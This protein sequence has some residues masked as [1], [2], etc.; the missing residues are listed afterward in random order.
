MSD[1]FH[2]DIETSFDSL[3]KWQQPMRN[4][5][6]SAFPGS[7]VSYLALPNGVVGLLVISPSFAGQTQAER[8]RR[9]RGILDTIGLGVE[10]LISVFHL[11]T[12]DENLN[13]DRQAAFQAC[14]MA[15]NTRL[16]GDIGFEIIPTKEMYSL[17]IKAPNQTLKAKVRFAED[18]LDAVG[19]RDFNA[20]AGIL[21]Q[22]G[23]FDVLAKRH[24]SRFFVLH[25][26]GLEETPGA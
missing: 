9:V 10:K 16:A 7:R 11:L 24:G 21:F 4:A 18:F 12:P 13:L 2:L 22:A 14:Y 19:G 5:L 25:A 1:D 20:A 8:E 17:E 3:G 6:L 15:L 26:D 23:L